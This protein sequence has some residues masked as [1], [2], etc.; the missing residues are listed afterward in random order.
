MR[1]RISLI[2]SSLDSTSMLCLAVG[3]AMLAAGLAYRGDSVVIT[4][5]IVLGAGMIAIGI[6]LPR[7][8][9][10]EIGLGGVKTKMAAVTD[11]P[12]LIDVPIKKLSE[13]A[14]LTSGD[15]DHAREIVEEA[16][17]RGRRTSRH[18]SPAERNLITL[19][20]LV[21]LLDTVRERTWLSGNASAAGGIPHPMRATAIDA[22]QGVPFPVRVIFL[23]HAICL[24]TE[25]DIAVLL[26]RTAADVASSLADARA[27]LSPYF[28][29]PAGGGQMTTDG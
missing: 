5:F 13:F 25:E 4:T 15:T 3:T 17:A 11:E 22:L 12:R 10:L 1:S 26:E 9:E 16:L 18:R 8:L 6:M 20:T 14:F 2:S 23:L 7:M 27:A 24:L 28:A 19:R 21:G 29:P